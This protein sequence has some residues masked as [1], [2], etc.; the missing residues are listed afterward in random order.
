MMPATE[1]QGGFRD[2]VMISNRS[3]SK[4]VTASWGES[5]ARMQYSG[6]SAHTYRSRSATSS[7]TWRTLPRPRATSS[8]PYPEDPPTCRH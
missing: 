7:A 1:M 3:A 6:R 2:G 5:Q 8:T 4:I